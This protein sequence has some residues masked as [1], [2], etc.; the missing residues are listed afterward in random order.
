MKVGDLVK[1][2]YLPF[3]YGIVVMIN[4][5]SESLWVSWVGEIGITGYNTKDAFLSMEVINEKRN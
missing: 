4:R 2:R 1:R 5:N 3:T